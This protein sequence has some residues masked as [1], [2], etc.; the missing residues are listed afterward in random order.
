MGAKAGTPRSANVTR[1][2]TANVPNSW[3]GHV[4]REHNPAEVDPEV[5]TARART[6]RESRTHTA[7]YDE[8]S[9]T[10]LA[11]DERMLR[12]KKRAQATPEPNTT[13]TGKEEDDSESDEADAMEVDTQ[14]G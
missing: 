9:N 11:E 10:Y 4:E 14:H 1:A 8:G 5:A 12:R 7:S 3:N 2:R 13:A 6:A